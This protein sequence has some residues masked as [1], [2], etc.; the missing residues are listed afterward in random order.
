MNRNLL[1]FAL[2]FA[3][4]AAPRS[5]EI[6]DL[7]LRL[8]GLTEDLE[9]RLESAHVAGMSLAIVKD[10]EVIYARGFG[11]ADVERNVPATTETLYAIGSATKAF[12]AT[13]IGMLVDEGRMSWD[14]PIT[15]HLPYFRL[16][17]D[18]HELTEAGVAEPQ[19]TLRDLLSHRTGFTRM[20]ILWAAGSADRETVLRTATKAEPWSPF[21]KAFFYNNVMYLA[22]G[23]AA[24]AVSGKSWESLIAER[25]FEPLGMSD[26]DTSVAVA[27]QDDR[28]ALGYLWDEEKREFEHLPMRHLGSIAP[29]GAINSNVLD[30]AQWVR[31]Q[32]GRGKLEGE[33]LVSARRI[34]D[35]WS[36]QT[37]L[38]EGVTYGLGW[39]LS[40]WNGQ[41]VVEHG[42]NIDGFSSAVALL[43]RSGIGLVLLTNVSS[44]PLQQS[45]RAIVWEALLGPRAEPETPAEESLDDF[46]GE[47]VANYAHFEDE[48][49]TVLEQ[50]GRLAIHIPSQTTYELLE[51]DAEG[52]RAFAIAPEAIQAIFER[53]ATGRVTLLRLHQSGLAFDVPRKG[54]VPAPD[55]TEEEFARYYG[56][57]RHPLLSEPFTV[58]YRNGRLACDIP[59]QMVFELRP[60]DR[61][62]R[63]RFRATD[64]I[65]LEFHEDDAGGIA[66]ITF[67][68]RGTESLCARVG[69]GTVE[70]VGIDEVLALRNATAVEERL[71]ALGTLRF[72]G[73]IRFVHAG[74]TGTSV[75]TFSA[76]GTFRQEAAFPPFGWSLTAFDGETGWTE[77]AFQ[78]YDEVEGKLLDQLRLSN[79]AVF[80]GDWRRYFDRL[81]VLRSSE[82]NGR[83]Q[84]VV[85]LRKG[86]LPAWMAYVDAETGDVTRVDSQ[87]LVPG[88]GTLPQTTTLGDWREQHGLRLPHR[89]T[90]E[91]PANG[92]VVAEFDLIEVG[93]EVPEGFYA[94]QQR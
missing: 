30:M 13:C 55:G 75:A 59:G 82:E 18:A 9:A 35:T 49:F 78:A 93:V 57:Y 72:S 15:R 86:E 32:L 76:T 43:P 24:A 85:R 79:P 80:F 84:W 29:A 51:P 5:V 31:L 52:M 41:P 38:G 25:L 67:H 90:T 47:Y 74:V 2:L 26:S 63:W 27:Q 14:D 83:H 68:E 66:S 37:P 46:L 1:G 17:I 42:G 45:I 48:T 69:E 28:L 40:E 64:E 53:D 11:L 3:A 94:P 92:R 61:R 60:P 54:F 12:T 71:A 58:L 39:F 6:P 88:L 44:T 56:S 19:V 22:A 65:A 21:R 23:E 87:T 10:D 91:T 73:P 8:Q 50:N 4:C 77:S 89:V 34:E 81:E 20:G 70:L 36:K 7:D 62:G 33:R 16:P